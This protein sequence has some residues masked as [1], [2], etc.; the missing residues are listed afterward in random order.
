MFE[1]ITEQEFNEQLTVGF[2]NA[3][4]D[5]TF[6]R[7]GVCVNQWDNGMGV[8]LLMLYTL[9]SDGVRYLRYE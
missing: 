6:N 1:R 5:Y 9:D 7:L 8:G 2:D 4:A 3:D